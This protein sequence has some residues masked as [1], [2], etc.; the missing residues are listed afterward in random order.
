MSKGRSDAIPGETVTALVRRTHRCGNCIMWQQPS[1]RE[2]GVCEV[3][4]MQ[5]LQGFD[6][7]GVQKDD[8]LFW[9]TADTY[10]DHQVPVPPPGPP[11][12]QCG[13][14]LHEGFGLLG[15]GYGAYEVCM[16]PGCDYI[17]KWPEMDDSE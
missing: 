11:C 4:D 17:Q 15:G 10:C 2:V 9:T 16:A 1:G 8:G 6:G 3:G 7:N 12:P 5:P 14:E 13:A